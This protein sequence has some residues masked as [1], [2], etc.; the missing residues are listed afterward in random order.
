MDKN[1]MRGIS[2]IMPTY[3]QAEFIGRAILS[4]LG[5]TYPQ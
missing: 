4:L 5:Q 1:G 3:N 2:V